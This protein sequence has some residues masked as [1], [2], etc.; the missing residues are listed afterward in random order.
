MVLCCYWLSFGPRICKW[1]GTGVGVGGGGGVGGA[2]G[3]IG[4]IGVQSLGTP[5][6]IKAT[7]RASF[8]VP[9]LLRKRSA[10]IA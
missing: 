9:P 6:E 2:I 1:V 3:V 5:F 10:V 4:G 7:H 8:L